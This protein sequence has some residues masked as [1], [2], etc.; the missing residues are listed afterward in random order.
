MV[1]ASIVSSLLLRSRSLGSQSDPCP[2]AE[3]AQVVK[4]LGNGRLEAQCFDGEKRLAHIRGK[5]RKKVSAMFPRQKT[6][7]DRDIGVDKSRRYHTAVPTRV[8]RRQGRCHRQVHSRRGP[9][10]KGTDLPS[11]MPYRRFLMHNRHTGSY[12]RTPKSTRLTPMVAKATRSSSSKGMT[13]TSTSM[14]FN[15]CFLWLPHLLRHQIIVL[16]SSLV[17]GLADKPPL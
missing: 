8:P 14:I 6:W 3:Y 12:R 5:M 10:P 15:W 7:S 4:M 9:K 1:K 11:M 17:V 2:V 16:S 13:R